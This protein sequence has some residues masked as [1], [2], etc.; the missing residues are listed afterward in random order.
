M[1]WCHGGGF[2]TG[3]G[4]S[5]GTDGTNLARRGDVVVV[6]H[7]PPPERARLHVP[8][9]GV[10]PRLRAVGRRRHA[11]HRAGAASGCATNIEQFGGDPST[12]MIFGQ[13]GG[14]RKSATLLDDA[15]GERPVPPR[16]HRERRDDQ[17]GRSATQP[18]RSPSGCSRS[19][20]STTR[21][22]ASC[23][24]CRCDKI[25]SAY[26]AVVKDMAASTR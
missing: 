5:P 22:C 18:P 7:Q 1:F 13:S 11:R 4:S 2:A 17:A 23:R 10:R 21:S 8:R 25:M 3:S 20:R 19:S 24:A 26:F 9:R 12:V 6:T 16:R 15:V 14:G